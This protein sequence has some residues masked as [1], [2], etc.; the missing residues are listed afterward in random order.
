MKR[1]A[2]SNLRCPFNYRA[3]LEKARYL[4]NKK[5]KEYVLRDR[6]LGYSELAMRFNVSTGT[7]FA[8]ATRK[9][10]WK[11]I[12]RSARIAEDAFDDLQCPF[13][14]KKELNEACEALNEKLRTCVS[15]HS[16]LSYIRLA[17][18]FNISVGSLFAVS[19]G[20]KKKLRPRP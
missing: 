3:E 12:M 9:Q 7:F 14:Y 6:I 1:N 19:Q 8:I 10:N 4:L 11:P 5:V 15:K 17:I 2:L 18:K 16:T 20:H 13:D